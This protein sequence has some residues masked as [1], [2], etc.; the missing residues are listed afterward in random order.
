[1]TVRS[2][3]KFDGVIIFCFKMNI[4]SINSDLS[5]ALYNNRIGNAWSMCQ[6]LNGSIYFSTDQCGTETFYG[7]GYALKLSQPPMVW[8]GFQSQK[9]N[10]MG[11][12]NFVRIDG[13]KRCIIGTLLVWFLITKMETKWVV[14]IFS[15]TPLSSKGDFSH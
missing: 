14:I 10:Q 1:M 8:F 15:I 6:V 11:S 13:S 12:Y 9:R 2:S 5:E 3:N 7:K 4:N